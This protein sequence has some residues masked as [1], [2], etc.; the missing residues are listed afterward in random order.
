MGLMAIP[1]MLV[2]DNDDHAELVMRAISRQRVSNGHSIALNI[3]RFADGPSAL[4]Y[5]FQRGAYVD[6]QNNPRPR[7]IL[8]DLR[9]PGMDGFEVLRT[10]KDSDEL[11]SIPVVVLTS[12]EADRDVVEAYAGQANSYL[13]KPVGF[14]AFSELMKTLVSYWFGSNELP[15]V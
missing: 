3:R 2:E 1:I 7:L 15:R 9:L 10:V 11:R 6:P 12:S 14:E 5:I 13:V 8:L 4:D